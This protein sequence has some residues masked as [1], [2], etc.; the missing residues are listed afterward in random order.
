ML[1]NITAVFGQP[2][3]G[4]KGYFKTCVSLVSNGFDPPPPAPP[5]VLVFKFRFYFYQSYT[6]FKDSAVCKT[7]FEK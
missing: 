2:E 4:A 3:I 5:R 7:Y 1:S 6:W